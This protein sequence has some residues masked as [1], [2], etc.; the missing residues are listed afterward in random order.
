V[1]ITEIIYNLVMSNSR[2]RKA[3][4][5]MAFG[6]FDGLHPG[7]T[8]FFRQARSLSV[9]PF[10]VVSVARDVNVRRLKGRLPRFNEKERV[11]LVRESKLTDKVILGGKKTHLEHILREK[12]DIV[13]LGY[14]QRAY[15]RGLKKELFARGLAVKIVRLKPYKKNI[16]KSSLLRAGN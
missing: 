12:P 8:N 1:W 13:A 9:S 6:V 14:D 15:V 3:E 5:I 4:K 2:R 11:K 16:Y 10:L 7:H